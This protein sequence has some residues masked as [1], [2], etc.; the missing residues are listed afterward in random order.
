MPPDARAPPVRPRDRS[1]RD[2]RL[3]AAVDDPMRDA[4]SDPPL[5]RDTET[6]AGRPRAVRLRPPRATV[7]LLVGMGVY[8]AM[9]EI[10]G[11]SGNLAVLV[12]FGAN[13]GPLVAA[14]ESWRLVASIFLHAGL[15]HLAVLQVVLH[16]HHRVAR[17]EHL[18]EHRQDL[19]RLHHLVGKNYLLL[20]RCPLHQVLVHPLVL[21]A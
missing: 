19:L 13:F 17:Q 8:F 9:T 12:A 15:L 10:A 16:L 20:Q 14:G 21:L 2:P 1:G 7:A 3:I 4:M 11:G 6:L 18:L 5:H